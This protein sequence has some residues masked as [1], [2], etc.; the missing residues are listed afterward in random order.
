[1]I[2]II[3]N[4]HLNTYNIQTIYIRKYFQILYDLYY[5]KFKPITFY[6]IHI[7]KKFI[8]NKNKHFKSLVFGYIE[9]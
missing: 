8:T 6:Q 4:C 1:M 9:N 3:I 7:L 2:I 5:L